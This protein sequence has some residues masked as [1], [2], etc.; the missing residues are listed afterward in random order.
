MSENEDT[1]VLF[2]YHIKADLNWNRLNI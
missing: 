1:A 2:N